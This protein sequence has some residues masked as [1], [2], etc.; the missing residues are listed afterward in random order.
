MKR[1]SCKSLRLPDLMEKWIMKWKKG[2]FAVYTREGRRFVLPLDYLKHPIFQVL[3]EIAEEEFGSTICGPLQVPCDGSLMDHILMLLRKR[4][5]SSHSGDD[6]D[7]DVKKNKKNYVVSSMSISC[8]G[9]SSVLY[10]FLLFH[11]NTSHD[12]SKLQSLVF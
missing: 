10:F 2:H 6:D 9:A 3:L 11:C 7:N 5:L 1:G 12:Q 4:S 8:K